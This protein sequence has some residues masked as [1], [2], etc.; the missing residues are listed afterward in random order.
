MTF[1]AGIFSL[2]LLLFPKS[3]LEKKFPFFA[4]ASLRFGPSYVT[5]SFPFLSFSPL[6]YKTLEGFFSGGRFHLWISRTFISR[7]AAANRVSNYL[8]ETTEIIIL[9]LNQILF[10]TRF[11]TFS[12]NFSV[13]DAIL[14]FELGRAKSKKR[15]FFFSLS[16]L[17][18]VS[19]VKIQLRNLKIF[20][21][22]REFPFFS[23]FPR[24]LQLVFCG[25][26]IELNRTDGPRDGKSQ[27]L[28]HV[29][30]T[31]LKLFKAALL[32]S[33]LY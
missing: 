25:A 29:H 26:R 7:P 16:L 11:S 20:A 2:S 33:W 17:F 8:V 6:G 23:F 14:R 3:I 1:N 22:R 31:P 9:T 4:S 32:S 21:E 12:G 10:P 19:A 27:K 30:W 13:G 28:A 18:F 24:W 5:F 15:R